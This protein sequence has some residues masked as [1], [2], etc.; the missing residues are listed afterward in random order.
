[1]IELST[2]EYMALSGMR[3]LSVL[4]GNTRNCQNKEQE[5]LR[6]DEELGKIRARFKNEKVGFSFFLSVSFQTLDSYLL[7]DYCG[8]RI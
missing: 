1:M 6:V 3:G 4:I 2:W 7:G 8:E 5:R